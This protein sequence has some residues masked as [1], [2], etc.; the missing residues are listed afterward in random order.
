MS[1]NSWPNTTPYYSSFVPT[2]YPSQYIPFASPATEPSPATPLNPVTPVY[3][4]LPTPAGISSSSYAS[5]GT[6]TTSPA[7][8]ECRRKRPRTILDDGS[9]ES[10]LLK[11][12]QWSDE[13]AWDLPDEDILGTFLLAVCHLHC[14]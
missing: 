4:S 7:T 2:R 3:L 14:G 8:V 13:Q 11:V 12:S 1:Y 9:R 5:T 10:H 6:H